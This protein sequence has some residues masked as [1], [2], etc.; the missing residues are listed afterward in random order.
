M[1]TKIKSL[2]HYIFTLPILL[3]GFFT[4]FTTTS[5]S[6]CTVASSIC[7]N[8]SPSFN[9][10]PTNG[11][12]AGGSFANGGCST[13]AGGQH[14]YSFITVY[15]TTSG[16]LNLLIDGNSGSGYID[17]VVFNVPTGVAPCNAVLNPSNAIGCNFASNSGG[18]VQ[19]GTS[20]PC[21][22]SVPAPYV[23]A[24]QEIVIV[25]QSYSSGGSTSYTMELSPTG[26]Q[27]GP[28]NASINPVANVC[29]NANAFQL[30]A[31]NNGGTWSGPGVSASGMFTP[32]IAGPGTHTINYS[33][34]TAPCNSASSTT[35]TVLPTPTLTVSPT[36]TICPGTS[37]TLTASGANTYSWTPA[38]TLNTN[39]GSTVIATPSSAIIYTVVGTNAE[40]CSVSATTQ[41]N[42]SAALLVQASHNGPICKGEEYQLDA[43]A[44]AGAI[45]SWTGPNGFT[46][47]IQNPT[48]PNIQPNQA[49]TYV[50]HV[51]HNGCS[52]T[53]SIVLTLNSQIFANL[54]PVSDLCSNQASVP[55]QASINPGTW[56][57]P[58][59]IN[60]NFDPSIAQI[61]SNQIYYVIDGPCGDTS[62]LNINV[63]ALPVFTFVADKTT[64]CYPVTILFTLDS[65]NAYSM[66]Q[67]NFGETNNIFNSTE[68]TISYTYT[69]AGSFPVSVLVNNL[70]CSSTVSLANYIN[71]PENPVASFTANSF[72]VQTFDPTV[73]FLNQSDY[74]SSYQWSFG[75]LTTSSLENPIH[76][77]PQEEGYYEV[78]LVAYNAM[79]CADTVK[80][81]ITV[82]P[83]LIYFIPNSFTPDGDE[84]N[85]T[86]KPVF[87]SGYDPYNFVM[88]IYNR[89]GE[90][91]FETRDVDYGWDGTYG[92]VRCPDGLY[93]WV[94]RFGVLENDD[95]KVLSGHISIIK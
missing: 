51:N 48:I 32:A 36:Q 49:G 15:V 33:I 23:T 56:Y 9:F 6:Q 3:L 27:S 82:D 25:A 65:Q 68:D 22:S 2:V 77:Y 41:V 61:G 11:S 85:N 67:W 52:N 14:S 8:T 62:F 84:Y 95:K 47:S 13:G 26:A 19:F 94:I 54:T 76:T 12:Y 81:N 70:L 53:D 86:F 89:W 21:S 87:T 46:S 42:V 83:G 93:N 35:I 90:L 59:V 44:Y 4:L 73:H 37:A 88:Q 1:D 45:Y 79:G 40:G 38:A 16:P 60:Q 10:V 24:G 31:V 92:G 18:C 72:T 74:A 69:S 17:V 80:H 28:P 55:L 20:F 91:L 34:G 5:Y 39:T 29:R 43:S 75:D 30:T 78:T 50:V 71:I 63:V 64:G 7:A 57:G 66:A 58:G